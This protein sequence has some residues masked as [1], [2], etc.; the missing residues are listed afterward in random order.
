M[1]R[2][3]RI[4][5]AAYTDDPEIASRTAE[6]FARTGVGLALDGVDTFLSAGP[7]DEES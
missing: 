7:D 6:Q 4:S 2:K 5:L 1:T 3:V